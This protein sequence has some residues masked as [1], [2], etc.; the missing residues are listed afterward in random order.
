MTI[1]KH[2]RKRT[3]TDIEPILKPDKNDVKASMNELVRLADLLRIKFEN[4]IELVNKE[5]KV[6]TSLNGIHQQFLKIY[7]SIEKLN[8]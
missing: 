8:V 7:N 5:G 2:F 4:H 6:T 3:R 1:M